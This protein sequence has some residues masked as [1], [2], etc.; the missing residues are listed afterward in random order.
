MGSLAPMVPVITQ[1]LQ[2]L[3]AVTGLILGLALRPRSRGAG[4]LCFA[5][6]VVLLTGAAFEILWLT[7]I[8]SVFGPGAV[9]RVVVGAFAVEFVEALLEGA[10]WIL[11]VLA[12][13]AD[14]GRVPER[15]G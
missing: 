7:L 14:R 9:P 2:V 5:G 10:G 12:V 13:L 15:R 3:F 11:L 8:D 4:R 6:G 1:L